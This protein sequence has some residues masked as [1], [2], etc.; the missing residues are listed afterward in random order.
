MSHS[1]SEAARQPLNRVAFERIRRDII[2]CTLE[3]GRQVTEAQ[4]AARYELGKAPIRAAL[5]GLCQEGLVRA[6]PRRG[7]LITPITMR[8]AQD[9]FQLRMLLEPTA[10]R[11]SAGRVTNVPLRRL[12]ELCSV[13]CKPGE[14]STQAA[15][16]AHRELHLTIAHASGNQRLEDALT[17]LY[18]DVERLVH[19][20]VSRIDSEEMAGYRPL[21]SAMAAGD[22]DLAAGDPG[23][24]EVFFRVPDV[25]SA[26]RG[27]VRLG[28]TVLRAAAD[29][30][31]GR[32]AE[33]ADPM[34]ARFN[35]AG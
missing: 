16:D 7:Y 28:G 19:L 13:R 35:L 32:L 24:W 25:D 10:A 27:V 20:G 33:A 23:R 6:I 3:P 2:H 34:G 15:V 8:D 22:G 26:L 11:L 29:T 9:I 18:D 21:V 5:L 1:G 12:A 17:R 31:F 14:A 4:L 30:P